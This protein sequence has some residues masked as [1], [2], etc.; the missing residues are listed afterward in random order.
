MCSY[1][2]VDVPSCVYSWKPEEGIWCPPLACSAYS[3]EVGALLEPG[4][5]VFLAVCLQAPQ[6][7]GYRHVFYASL[8]CTCFDLNSGPRDHATLLTAVSG[9]VYSEAPGSSA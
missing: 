1:A 3:F 8:V 9:L 4:A 7:W 5:Y 2:C 6:S